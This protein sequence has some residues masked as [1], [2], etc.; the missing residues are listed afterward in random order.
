MIY[1]SFRWPGRV[2]VGE[3]DAVGEGAGLLDGAGCADEL[4]A[5]GVGFAALVVA[6]SGGAMVVLGG[7]AVAVRGDG[8]GRPWATLPRSGTVSSGL[9]PGRHST[10]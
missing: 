10:R 6:M 3:G 8:G 4:D 7:G 2:T 1:G 9:I 5:A